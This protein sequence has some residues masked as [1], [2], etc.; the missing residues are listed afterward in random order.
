MSDRIEWDERA[1]ITVS[2]EV[3]GAYVTRDATP[4]DLARAG[5]VPASEAQAAPKSVECGVR[6]CDDE[7]HDCG[8]CAYYKLGSFDPMCAECRTICHYTPKQPAPQPAAERLCEACG[9]EPDNSSGVCTRCYDMPTKPHWTP[10]KSRPA[11]EVQA[12]PVSGKWRKQIARALGHHVATLDDCPRW[13][14]LVAEVQQRCE[15]QA[16]TTWP[17]VHRDT[18]EL[19]MKV[20][21]E[22]RYLTFHRDPSPLAERYHKQAIA[23]K[24]RV[25]EL[26]R[27]LAEAR[28]PRLDPATVRG[29]ARDRKPLD[30]ADAQALE[31][32]LTMTERE[33]DAA[34]SARDEWAR[35]CNM[36]SEAQADALNDAALVRRERDTERIAREKAEA[37]IIELE[38]FDRQAT[39]QHERNIAHIGHL[40]SR[41][42]ELGRRLAA[43]AAT[44]PDPPVAKSCDNCGRVRPDGFCFM[45]GCNG[46]SLKDW[47]PRDTK[48]DPRDPP[49]EPRS[50]EGWVSQQM[51]LDTVDGLY[52]SVWRSAHDFH[53]IRVR[54]TE[55]GN[56]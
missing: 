36:T 27:E 56:G 23:A 46:A 55:V 43:I 5:Y 2:H 32:A 1:I 21:G 11:S 8:D 39:Q 51:F 47:Q 9:T 35:Q 31:G 30:G 33:R 26:E 10:R 16:A 42:A 15:V 45:A 38:G 28:L 37:R 3:E 13:V 25:E 52:G 18:V 40:E 4:A 34:I 53:P 19:T 17:E 48:P 41:I 12:E 54:V 14:D 24:E 44:P 49:V 20:R 50:R 6:G 7:D 29:A 22:A